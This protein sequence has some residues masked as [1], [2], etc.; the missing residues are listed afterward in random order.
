MSLSY[1]LL[2]LLSKQPD[3]G[4]GL[5]RLLRSDVGHVWEARLQQIYSE[6]ARLETEGLV[7]SK[8]EPLP[9]RPAKKCYSVTQ[10]G[11]EELDRWLARAPS[12]A[13][14]RDEL[15]VRL[16][17]SDRL[18]ESVVTRRLEEHRDYHEQR[19]QSLREQVAR[20]R[21]GG[22]GE[23]GY[24]ITLE[25]AL[26][27]SEAHV[28]WAERALALLSRRDGKNGEVTAPLRRSAAN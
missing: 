18:P 23:L 7:R 12:P 24:T 1:V 21:P 16:L 10:A 19:A 26:L 13:P 3:S 14:C 25:A 15:L 17:C 20:T 11:Y 22:R 6:L 2:A 9:N 28:A 4:Y 27:Q 8:A 5:G